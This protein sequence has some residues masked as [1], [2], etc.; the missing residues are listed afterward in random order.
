MKRIFIA[1]D[2]SEEARQKA[3]EY[4][5]KLRHSFS[6]VR[7]GWEQPEKLHQTLK[8]L[9]NVSERQVGAVQKALARV[10]VSFPGFKANLTD[11][12]VFPAKGRPRILWI[13]V[14]ADSN[15]AA[16]ADQAE[17]ECRLLGFR[18]DKRPF[19]PHLTIARLRE[20]SRSAD[21]VAQHLAN[22]FEPVTFEVREI[23][24]Y[25]S[26]LRP[27]GSIYTKLASIPLR[28]NSL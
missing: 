15:L 26:E 6:G 21:V 10:A 9:G 28:E 11:T 14:E 4:A 27:A 5:A 13:G 8:F 2:I 25:E 19:R 22:R 3:A 17:A 12:G 24:I 18:S 23:V 20:P 16:I 7:I 1:I